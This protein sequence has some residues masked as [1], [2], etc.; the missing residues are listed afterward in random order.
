MSEALAPHPGRPLET[1][2][3]L[4]KAPDEGRYFTF[5]SRP[6]ETVSAILDWIQPGSALVD[7]GCGSGSFLSFVKNLKGCV[8][9]GVESDPYR[10]GQAQQQG[11]SIIHGSVDDMPR[12]QLGAYDIVTLLD[13]IEHI[14][15]PGRFLDSCR[16]L[17]RPNGLMIISVP[18]VA[19]WT[20]RLRLLRGFFEYAPVGIMD[21][22]HLRW[23]TEHT[24]RRFLERSGVVQLDVRHVP[25][26]WMKEYEVLPRPLRKPLITALMAL[27]PRLISPKI[28]VRARWS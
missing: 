8:V 18:N 4:D 3:L 10:A 7:V 9:T 20:V 5:Q 13:V 22:T 17:L 23:F 19:H 21:A 2:Y 26:L 28:I 6:P 15:N 12:D 1:P 27:C 16:Q 11:L 25:G 14:A 24:L